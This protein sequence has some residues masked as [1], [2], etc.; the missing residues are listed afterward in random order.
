MEKEQKAREGMR[1]PRERR[2]AGQTKK[3]KGSECVDAKEP[4][5]KSRE[6]HETPSCGEQT[7][8]ILS[9]TFSNPISELSESPRKQKGQ[10]TSEVPR[11][12]EEKQRRRG[13][14]EMK[15]T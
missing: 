10:R 15:R 1:E 2:G 4:A 5:R 7:K 8:L 12:E 6:D 3:R 13:E 14:Q 9:I 11:D